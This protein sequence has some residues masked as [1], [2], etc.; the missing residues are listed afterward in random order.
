MIQLK[1]GG[2]AGIHFPPALDNVFGVSNN[3]QF[4]RNFN[5]INVDDLLEDGETPSEAKERLKEEGDPN[6]I[7][8]DIH[9]TIDSNLSTIR[10]HLKKQRTGI[11][12]SSNEN[13]RHTAEKKAT[14]LTR[15]RQEVGYHGESDEGEN[16]PQEAREKSD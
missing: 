9:Q 13:K 11:R 10:T 6:G 4:A 14:D 7:L 2:V 1:D 16:L 8:L 3:K 15:E 12:S 5:A